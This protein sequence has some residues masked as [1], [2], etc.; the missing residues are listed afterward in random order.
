MTG[1]L[2]IERTNTILY[3]TSWKRTVEFYRDTLGFAVT[4]ENDWFVEFA[5]GGSSHLS[6]ADADRATVGA[7]DGSGITLSWQ[8]LDI[9]HAHRMLAERGAEPGQIHRRWGATA[10]QLHD[11]EG[12]R[13]ECWAKP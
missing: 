1:L 8:V 11:P 13:I 2:I 4:F 7:T 6:V 5:L 9:D 10:F 12:H 3:C